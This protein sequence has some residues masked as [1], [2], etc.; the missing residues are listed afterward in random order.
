MKKLYYDAKKCTACKTCEIVCAIGHSPSKDLYT[1]I[2]ED[3]AALP[4][5]RVYAGQDENYPMACR[6]CKDHPCVSACIASALRYDP[7]EGLLFDKEK[8]VG[9]WMC[10]MVCP[11]GA[12]RPDFRDS[13]SVR[14]DL[15]ADIKDPRC[16]KNCPTKAIIYVEEKAINV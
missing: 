10:I 7:K 16:A 2:L 1:A 12:V 15:C 3:N 5:V 13:K 9:C 8:C 14:C 11:Y 4:S 6:H